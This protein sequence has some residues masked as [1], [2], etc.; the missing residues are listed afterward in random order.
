MAYRPRFGIQGPVLGLNDPWNR[1]GSDRIMRTGTGRLIPAQDPDVSPEQFMIGLKQLGV[2]FYVHHLFPDAEELESLIEDSRK[3]QIKLVIG[4][5]YGNIN[6]PWADGTNRYDVP[7]HIVQ[8]LSDSGQLE[9]LQYDEPEHL[10]INASQYRKE[11]WLPHWGNIEADQL[12]QAHDQLVINVRDSLSELA[13]AL[14]DGQPI[15]SE[16]VFPT[17]FHAHARAGLTPAPKMM[18]ESFQTLQLATA[19]GAAKQYNKGLWICSDLWGPDVGPWSTRTAGFPGHSPE[20]FAAALRLGYHMSPSHLFVENIDGLIRNH[21]QLGMLTTEFG[22]VWKEFLQDYVP[23]H[24]LDYSHL[25][26]DPDIVIIH[27]DDSNYGQNE[28]PFGIRELTMPEHS[29]SLF[30]AWH[31]VTHGTIPTHGSCLHIPGYSFPRH[32]LQFGKEPVQYP[33]WEG[34]AQEMYGQPIHPLFQPANNVLVYDAYATAETIG[35]PSL[36]II[37]G[38]YISEETLHACYQLAEQGACVI[39][40]EW[41]LPPDLRH[42]RKFDSGGAWGPVESLLGDTAF[43]YAA[44]Y[45]GSSR[46]WKQRFGDYTVHIAPSDQQGF[47]LDIEVLQAIR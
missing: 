8:K 41:L 44:P 11:E 13:D 31:L 18:K 35:K 16:Q 47:T 39:A 32:K 6:G 1:A 25:Q 23:Q 3:H 40:G 38:S 36:V 28:R 33:L 14:P 4:N 12:R 15:L 9:A 7:L 19:L 5:E 45:L 42:S 43:E 21:E 34:V 2:E 29:Q 20:E 17:L 26:A 22:E 27:S 37:A 10:Q 24:P 46:L 30:H